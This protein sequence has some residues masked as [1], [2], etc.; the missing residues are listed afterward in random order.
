MARA[1]RNRPLVDHSSLRKLKTRAA[2]SPSSLSRNAV[3][4]RND[5]AAHRQSYNTSDKTKSQERVA[6]VARRAPAPYS[7]IRLAPADGVTNTSAV[8]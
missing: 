6:A 1:S 7:V 3:E 5:R 2:S 8:R 4:Q